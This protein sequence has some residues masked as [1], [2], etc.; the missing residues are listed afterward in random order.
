MDKEQI[1]QISRIPRQN[2]LKLLGLACINLIPGINTLNNEL[3]LEV[4]IKIPPSLML[5]S[6]D[7]SQLPNLI[8][9]IVNSGYEATTYEQY[10]KK[11]LNGEKPT[12][13]LLI[14]ID[15]IGITYMNPAF[16]RIIEIMDKARMV[17]TLGIVTRGERNEAKTDIWKYLAEKQKNGWE[18]AIHT[19]DHTSLPFLTDRELRFQIKETYEEIANATGKSPN[20]LILPYGNVNSKLGG[21]DRRIFD[22][23]KELGI[24]WVVGIPGGKQIS[25]SPPYFAGRVGPGRTEQIT[26]EYLANS[27]D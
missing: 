17:G 22:V 1:S 16:K 11:L 14:S 27:F 12:T 21:T 20:S 6:K 8:P 23:C 9:L 15:D 13:P 5:H 18:L 3:F 2:F 10:Y 7:L 26:M 24:W 19:E 4:P 25:G